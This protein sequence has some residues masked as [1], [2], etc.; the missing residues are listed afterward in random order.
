MSERSKKRW[1]TT[2]L[3]VAG[4]ALS[5]L[6]WCAERVIAKVTDGLEHRDVLEKRVDAAETTVKI[7]KEEQEK[8]RPHVESIPVILERVAEVKQ[9]LD[10]LD[11]L[12]SRMARIEQDISWLKTQKQRETAALGSSGIVGPIREP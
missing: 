1:K 3:S 8:R 2:L 9:K 4:L 5:C 6:G 11:S 7:I 10:K 12:D